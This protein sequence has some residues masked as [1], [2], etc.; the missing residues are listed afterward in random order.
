MSIGKAYRGLG[1]DHRLNYYAGVPSP[2]VPGR[3]SASD[4]ALVPYPASLTRGDGVFGLAVGPVV[5]TADGRLAEEAG[6][7]ARHLSITPGTDVRL[8]VT[9]AARAI[10]FVERPHDGHDESYELSVRPG[11]VRITAA[12]A[13]GAYRATQTL[14]QL[15]P[16]A[17]PPAW[18]CVEIA[19][20]PRFGWRGLMLD[21]CRHVFP[22]ADLL[23]L[24]DT[25][26]LHK[27]NVFHWHLTEDQGWRLFI[28]KH[29]ALAERGGFRAGG[30]GVLSPSKGP[31]L[32][33]AAGTYGGFYTHDDV[34]EV[35]AYAA[36][37]H[38]TVV[39]EIEMPGHA[40]AALTAYPGLA[41]APGDFKPVSQMG[42]FKD[43]FCAGNDATFAL[44]E[45]VLAEVCDLFP[46]PFVHVGGDEC[47]KDR[48]KTCPKCQ[49]RI[50]DEHL[51]DEHGLQS[52]FVRRIEK[53]LNARGKRLVGWD[54][55]LEGGLA[56]NAT[57]MSWRGT[58][59]GIAAARAGHD[60]VMTP[61][62]R[63][64][65]DYRQADAGEPPAIP[66]PV[67]SLADVYACEPV[68][69][70]LSAGEA[71]HVLG[72]QANLWTEYVHDF[73]HAEYMLWPR[74]CALAEIAWSPAAARDWAGFRS[75]L[76]EHAV[77]LAGLGVRFRP[78]DAAEN[79]I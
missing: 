32:D 42:V 48:W 69:A 57:V 28:Q 34:R 51:V 16:P 29:P 22:K 24:L 19:D 1:K 77:R 62:T 30:D 76:G 67:L 11:A 64:Y 71:K 10:H 25:M 31:R 39:P 47:P 46:G 14:A 17:G 6:R 75:R 20:R 61:H 21:V 53:F 4:F 38:I 79:A 74:A 2:P 60:V 58:E 33:P 41:C 3:D 50:K 72:V 70:E 65:F 35:V 12:T 13:A 27:L 73:A 26:A 9:P 40:L 43:V 23:R 37:R 45:D 49:A 36:E 59:G 66:G 8:S 63:V 15:L 44:L 55:I 5:V 18:P 52:Y 68:P 7:F 54:E 78:L 56:P